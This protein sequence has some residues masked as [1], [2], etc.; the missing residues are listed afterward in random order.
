MTTSTTVNV[1]AAK[2]TFCALVSQAQAGEQTA[3]VKQGAEVARL[4]PARSRAQKA[5]AAWRERRKGILL[6]R[7]GLPATTLAALYQEARP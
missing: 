6:N 3:I 7:E 1:T 5:T 4:V 2:K